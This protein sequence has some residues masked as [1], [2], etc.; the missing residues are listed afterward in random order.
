M[1]LLLK[2]LSSLWF[3]LDFFLSISGGIIVWRGLLIEKRAEQMLPPSDFRPDIFGDIVEKYKSEVERGWRILMIGIIVEVIAALGISVIS[4]LEIA[5][6]NDKAEL[7]GK[8]AA[9]SY[10][11]SVAFSMQVEELRSNNIVLETEIQPRRISD[12]QRT[13][14]LSE[15]KGRVLSSSGRVKV[16]AEAYDSESRIYALQL[17]QVLAAAGFKVNLDSNSI[18]SVREIDFGIKFLIHP[19]V[20]PEA[21]AIGRA[22]R[23]AGIMPDEASTDLQPGDFVLEIWVGAKPIK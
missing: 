4:G 19:D 17:A 7:A 15:L 14:I 9:A 22:F 18:N 8:D 10:S 23:L 2:L 11:N 12:K 6:L 5:S 16:T 1:T 13:I 20:E 21:R 3:W